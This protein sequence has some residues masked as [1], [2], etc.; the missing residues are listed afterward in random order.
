ME[1]LNLEGLQNCITG[2]RVTVILLNGL[3]FPIGQSGKASWWRVFFYQRGLPRLVYICKDNFI[4]EKNMN[5][6]LHSYCFTNVC[7][8][9]I[10]SSRV[11]ECLGAGPP[12]SSWLAASQSLHHVS[13]PR[14]LGAAEVTSPSQLL[15]SEAPLLHPSFPTAWRLQTVFIG[16]RSNSSRWWCWCRNNRFTWKTGVYILR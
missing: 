5:P 14:T 1:N 12:G 9:L 16:H 15:D 2:S 10:V 3:I 13:C 8:D 4:L 7:L 11:L 6:Q